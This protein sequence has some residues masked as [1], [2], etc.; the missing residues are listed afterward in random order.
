M[1]TS[2]LEIFIQLEMAIKSI[3][4]CQREQPPSFVPCG[5]DETPSSAASLLH[6]VVIVEAMTYGNLNGNSG[7][8]T[9]YSRDPE[10]GENIFTGE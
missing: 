2:L 9:V 1:H 10:T 4:I 6:R 5:L 3:S 7:C 8:G